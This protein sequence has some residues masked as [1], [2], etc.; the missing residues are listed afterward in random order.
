MGTA[1][2]AETQI[3]RTRLYPPRLP[4]IVTRQRLLTELEKA[5]AA[6]LA[7]IVA[8]AGY[9]KSTLAAQFLQVSQS[10][11][12]WYQLEENDSDLSVFLS[13]LVA[14]L[15]GVLADFGE[16]TLSH[17]GSVSN[18]AEQSRAILSTFI[19]ELDELV[20]EELFIALDDFHLVNDSG[21]ITEAMEFLLDHMLPNLH[22]IVISRS[23]PALSLTQLKARRELLELK[24]SDLSFTPDEAVA[25]FKDVFA[26]PLSEQ[27]IAALLES[28]EGWISG[29]VLFY[30][31]NKGK[32]A[33]ELEK[34]FNG[35]GTS[36]YIFEYLSKTVYESQPEKV[37]EFITKTSILSR[38][39]PRFCDELLGIDDSRAV[40]SRLTDERL[41]TI[42]LDDQGNWFRYHF[43]LQAFLQDTL[44]ENLAPGEIKDLHLKAAHMWEKNGEP[45]QALHHHMDAEAFE[46]AAEVL[47]SIIAELVQNSRISF[48]DRQ[49]SRLPDSVLGKHPRLLL[50]KAQIAAMFGDYEAAIAEASKSSL[51]FRNSGDVDREARSLLFSAAYHFS[52]AEPDDADHLISR[53]KEIAPP[54][55]E[56]NWDAMA[57]ESAIRAGAGDDSAAGQLVAEALGHAGEITSIRT[58]VRVLNWCGLASFLQGR[59]NRALTAFRDAD[60]LLEGAGPSATRAFVYALLSRTYAYLG[61]LQEARE[62]AV[63][64]VA[65]G[66]S[67]GF[68]PMSCLCQAAGAVA[69]A[70]SGDLA[71]TLDDVNAAAPQCLGYK[72]IGEIWY[73]QWFLGEACILLGD[74]DSARQ[75][76]QMF[77]Q[78]AG[79]FPWV[80]QLNRIAVAACLSRSSGVEK[81]MEEIQGILL[82]P[83]QKAGIVNSLARSLLF[84]LKSQGGGQAEARDVLETYIREFG[85]D[86]VLLNFTTDSEYLLPAFTD[87]FAEGRCLEFMDRVFSLVGATSLPLV[88]QLQQSKIR[89]VKTKA[90]ELTERFMREATD[91]LSIR[92]LGAFEIIQGSRTL[93]AADWKSKK[94]LM[95]FKYLAANRGEG[96]TPRDVLMEL[97]WS[98][99]PLESAQGSLN[100]ALTAVRKTL[101][102][103]AGRGESSYLVTKGD[104][105]RLELGAGGFSDLELFRD[106][107][108]QAVKAKE[109][110]DFD[111]FFRALK[112]AADLYAGEFCSEDLYEDWCTQ[113]RESLLADYVNVLVDLATE[114]LR[115]GEGELAMACLERAVSKDPGREEL[116]RKQ[117]TISSQVGHRAGVEETYRRCTAYLK[118]T[119]E[120]TPSPETTELYQ[121]LR[122]Q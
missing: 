77:E 101:E 59:F 80:P 103:G 100:A 74:D 24:E 17:L 117:M 108:S 51:A 92:M 62:T 39:N 26:M 102:P 10:P 82:S 68:A 19:G 107:L 64:G 47:E 2:A 94:A 21:Q 81:A 111:H 83:G 55:S 35:T 32:T 1:V 76:L 42:A 57:L 46:R 5:R 63:R 45:E 87:F 6:K 110:G 72:T 54:S 38:L 116:Y 66:E 122:Q 109:R 36:L 12:V 112:E 25:L 96:F 49:L 71:T 15:R 99:T 48:L 113:E 44:A 120:V 93:T 114:H 33:G 69:S 67:L 70:Y 86:I 95:A 34:S 11:F 3:L 7:V 27:V 78:M 91:P 28:T 13:Y 104:A 56:L 61:R 8:G 23:I 58:R 30:I 121:R 79:K 98:E 119:Y 22:F 50:Q 14:G 37:K 90:Q 89:E 9:G 53:V 97:L 43:G 75:H 85:A 52:I 29:L 18:V 105:L 60:A 41:F 118:D 20:A 88:R 31:A 73:A 115:R 106:R 65:I 4:E 84:R 16:K 40:I